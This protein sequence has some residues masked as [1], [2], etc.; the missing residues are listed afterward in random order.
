MSSSLDHQ[1]LAHHVH[2]DA[3]PKDPEAEKQDEGLDVD[4]LDQKAEASK[5]K[6]MPKVTMMLTHDTCRLD[7]RKLT[8]FIRSTAV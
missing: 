1:Y 5:L 6:Q 2:C 8:L 3:K 7:P 4:C